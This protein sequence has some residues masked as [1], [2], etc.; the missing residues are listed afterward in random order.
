MPRIKIAPPKEWLFTFNLTVRVTDLNY[1]NHLANE[2][3][4]AFAQEARVKFLESK[5]ASELDFFGTSLIQ[6]DAAI[7][8]QSE[9]FLSNEI[10]VKLGVSDVSNSSFDFVYKMNNRTTEKPLAMVKTRMV[11]FDYETRKVQP[12]PEAFK[13]LVGH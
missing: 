1:G 9:G 12:T 2:K 4:L 13:E 8:Y 3:V 5:S 6:G 10:E 11:C 7:V